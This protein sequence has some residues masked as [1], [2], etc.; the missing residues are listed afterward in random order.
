M[1]IELD[2]AMSQRNVREQGRNFERARE[3]LESDPVIVEDRR[4][5]HREQRSIACGNVGGRLLICGFTMRGTEL[6]IIL[7]RKIDALGQDGFRRGA[8]AGGGDTG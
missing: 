1:E 8:Q 4:R 5:N 7:L 2:R 6:R 3:L